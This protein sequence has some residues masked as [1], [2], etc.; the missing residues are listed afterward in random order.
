MVT[1]HRS[2]TIT[3]PQWMFLKTEAERLGISVSE[4][5]RRIIDQY[6]EGKG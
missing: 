4:L 3:E 5:M 6:R 1:M 2:F